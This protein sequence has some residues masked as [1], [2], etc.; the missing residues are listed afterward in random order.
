MTG[1]T[2][3]EDPHRMVRGGDGL[4]RDGDPEGEGPTYPI[5]QEQYNM[6]LE[7]NNF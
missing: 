3:P 7:E 2:D 4:V 1:V 6:G 5:T